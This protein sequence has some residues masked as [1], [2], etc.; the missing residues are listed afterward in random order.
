MD[1]AFPSSLGVAGVRLLADEVCDFELDEFIPLQ[2]RTYTRAL[3]CGLLRLG[4]YSLTLLELTVEPYTQAVRGVTLT[5]FVSF[6]EWPPM[7]VDRERAG[8]PRLSTKFEGWGVEDLANEF[9]V[10][11]RD[12][13]AL[14]H[15]GRLDQCEAYSHGR[16]R[17]LIHE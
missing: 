1:E 16:C 2:V 3:G 4:D 10:S 5:S 12:R 8:V 11:R 14:I 17:F 7:T 6:S 9:R 15:W 13:E